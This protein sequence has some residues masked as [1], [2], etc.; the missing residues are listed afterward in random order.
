MGYADVIADINETGTTLRS[1]HLKPISDGVVLESQACL[2]VNR[3]RLINNP[4]LCQ[5]VQG[6][7]E[8]I[9]AHQRASEL[10]SV[11]AN[12]EGESM[13]AVAGAVL[14]RRELAG[15][16]GPT[17]MP[18]FD[19][20]APGRVFAVTLVV[21]RQQLAAVKDHLRMLGGGAITVMQSLYAFEERSTYYEQL[22]ERLGQG[23]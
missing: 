3:A 18:V 21:P 20:A 7:L 17:I 10:L 8:M 15:Q 19:P 13:Q 12:V 5:I 11:T 16:R 2:L 23:V 4:P 1:N 6:I 9:E 14:A 22:V